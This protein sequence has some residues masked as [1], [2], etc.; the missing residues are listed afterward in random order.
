MKTFN[1][2]LI[3][4]AS[5]GSLVAAEGRFSEDFSSSIYAR[6]AAVDDYLDFFPLSARDYTAP[7]TAP[8]FN[9]YAREAYVP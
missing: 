2:F 9:L 6:D 1:A 4:I 5:L 7:L 8:G 3:T